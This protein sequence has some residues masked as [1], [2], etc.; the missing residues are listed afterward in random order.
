MH[1]GD[2]HRDLTVAAELNGGQVTATVETSHD[3]FQSVL[4]KAEITVQHGVHTYPLDGLRERAQT[5]RV[6]FDL[7]PAPDAAAT[8]VVD[9]FRITGQVAQ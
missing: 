5:V 4:S 8:P 2:A 1:A 9:G 3:E 7:T 6:R